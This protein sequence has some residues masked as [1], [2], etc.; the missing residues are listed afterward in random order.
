MS[1]CRTNETFQALQRS[2][3]PKQ[4]VTSTSHLTC[5]NQTHWHDWPS[6]GVRLNSSNKLRVLRVHGR[7]KSPTRRNMCS[8]YVPS[9]EL[10]ITIVTVAGLGLLALLRVSK[11]SM[12]CRGADSTL[13]VG[14][15]Q[16]ALLAGS[17]LALKWMWYVPLFLF[18][19][20]L[21]RRSLLLGSL[22]VQILNTC[23]SVSYLSNFQVNSEPEPTK[24]QN[25][26]LERPANSLQIAPLRRF[27][28]SL[29]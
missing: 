19:G 24:G 1:L 17:S 13:V 25:A 21:A 23:R 27:G 14:R 2:C 8:K 20:R 12:C 29:R 16:F 18:R 3:E 22:G 5:K 11:L 6:C 26:V 10:V 7:C 28:S 9:L 4:A 15:H